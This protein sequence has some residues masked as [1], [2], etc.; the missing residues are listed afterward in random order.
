[1][2]K[3]FFTLGISIL[4]CGP[5]KTSQ[6]TEKTDAVKTNIPVEQTVKD[7]V[8]SKTSKETIKK[9]TK[10]IAAISSCIKLKIDSFK[11]AQRHEQPQKVVEYEYKGKKV[12]YV[13]MPC[14][15]FFNQVYD[16]KCNLLG[17]PD[18]GFTG[19]GDGKLPDFF[20]E[21][22]NE[23]LIWEAAK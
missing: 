5:A 21:A 15:D 4:S 19:R 3:L 9:N 22:K 1:M 2:I 7:T 13:V 14:C 8:P 11:V 20:K 10:N 23:K 6:A 18:G 12:Y 17:A 16:E